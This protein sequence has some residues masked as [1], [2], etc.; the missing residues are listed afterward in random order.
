MAGPVQPSAKPKGKILAGLLKEF[1]DVDR[2]P[3]HLNN[4][5]LAHPLPCSSMWMT[6]GH[7]RNQPQG[8]ASS[9]GR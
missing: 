8:D 4:L 5:R 2:S 6:A 7:I 9:V 1:T 3:N